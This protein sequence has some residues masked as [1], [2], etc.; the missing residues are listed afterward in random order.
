[1]VSV[2]VLVAIVKKR[3]GFSENRYD[4]P[5]DPEPDSIRTHVDGTMLAQAVSSKLERNSR[6][7]LILIGKCC[8]TAAPFPSPVAATRSRGRLLSL[9]QYEH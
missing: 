9:A 2:D 5:P 3:F 8:G 1:V 4:L 7:R 6:A